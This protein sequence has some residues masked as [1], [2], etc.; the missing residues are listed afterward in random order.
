[1]IEHMQY[2]GNRAHER[3]ARVDFFRG[4]ALV[5][6]FIDHVPG[7]ALAK[8]T[9]T[10][11]GFADAAEVFV[12]LAGYASV[13]AYQRTFAH[14][15]RIG[16]AKVATRV[17]DLYVAHL[18]VLVVCVA[19]LALAAR[20]FQNPIYFEHVNLIPFN[21]EPGGAIARALIL[22][23]QPGYLNILPL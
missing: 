13:L 1:M 9:L 17:R 15:W 7:N 3:D 20:A 19:G 2:A 23:Y 6:I 12:L 14:D 11:F 4:L 5:F 16:T 21:I 8:V 10:N 18:I 22:R